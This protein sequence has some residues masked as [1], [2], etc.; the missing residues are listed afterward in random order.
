MEI[1]RVTPETKEVFGKIWKIVFGDSDKWLDIYMNEYIEHDKAFFLREERSMQSILSF[2][3]HKE[4]VGKDGE[5]Y[6][7]APALYA[8]ATLPG[9]RGKGLFASLMER[10]LSEINEKGHTAA[11]IFPSEEWLFG[12]YRDKF[13]FRDYYFSNVIYAD[14]GDIMPWEYEM[15]EGRELK[16][17]VVNAPKYNSLREK[18]LKGTNHLVFNEAQIKLQ[19]ETA[20]LSGGNLY[21]IKGGKDKAICCI[22]RMSGK[23]VRV[24]ELL[25]DPGDIKDAVALIRKNFHGD[26]YEIRYPEGV[27]A[28]ID[29][30]TPTVK[31]MGQLKVFGEGRF[32]DKAYAGF[33]FD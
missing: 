33:M 23:D 29:N 30:V 4:L 13:G 14:S 3:E 5:S 25:A 27:F 24:T 11:S 21:E 32:P 1:N 17:T 28:D 31:C 22:E 6:G 15:E 7:K 8:G 2:Y 19:K 9:C 20:M 18:I 26:R 12:Y 16:L 10:V